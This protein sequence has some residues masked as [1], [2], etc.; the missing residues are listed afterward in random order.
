[1]ERSQ[2]K[3]PLCSKEAMS[4]NTKIFIDVYVN[5]CHEIVFK[6]HMYEICTNWSKKMERSQVL[7][8]NRSP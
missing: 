3:N 5:V 4:K 2:G 7:T 1:M 8:S 6:H